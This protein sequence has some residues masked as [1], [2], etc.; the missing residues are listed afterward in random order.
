MPNTPRM[1]TPPAN[2]AIATST[3]GKGLQIRVR[4]RGIPRAGRAAMDLVKAALRRVARER[5]DVPEVLVRELVLGGID[6]S[7]VPEVEQLDDEAGVVD[8]AGACDFL[9]RIGESE[10]LHV[11]FQGYPDTGFVDRLFRQHLTLALRYPE[12]LVT[13]VAFWL[14]RSP[15]P[16][17]VEVI[18]RGRVMLHLASVV[19]P[20]LKAARLLARE[21]TACFAACAD[22]EGWSNDELCDLVVRAMGSSSSADC[23]RDAAIALASTCGRYQGMVRALTAER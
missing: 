4:A 21:E 20:E 1:A 16:D 18:R 9:A 19:L 10:M 12:R 14:V 2:A 5:P 22:A 23:L 3:S 15:R 13:T 11:E 8:P 17:R 6:P 7:A